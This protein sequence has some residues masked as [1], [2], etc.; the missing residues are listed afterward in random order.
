MP[1]GVMIVVGLAALFTGAEAVVRGAARLAQLLGARPLVIGLTIVGMGTSAPEV[2]VSAVAAARGESAVAL[3]NVLGSNIANVGL[4]LALAALVCPMRADI[5]L[6]RRETPLLLAFSVGCYGLAWTGA[7]T[8][9]QGALL[10]VGLVAF[11]RLALRWA[12][13]EPVAIEREF[14]EFEG[15]L[16]AGA[17][18]PVRATSFV[19]AGLILLLVGG[20]VLVVAAVSL[21]RSAGISEAAIAATLVAAGTSLPELATSLVAAAR[22]QPDIAVGNIIGSNLFNLLGVL[23][24]AAVIRPVEVSLAQRDFEFPVML[25]F[26]AAAAVMLRTG[27]RFTRVEGALLLAAYAAFCWLLLR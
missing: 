4:I 15:K 5:G 26:T 18:S 7:Y 20:H 1:D 2:V 11:V 13:S 8:R 14:A 17:S 27:H 6:L 22:R 3:G 12:R 21:A 24:L 9:W 10:L 16:L 23:G 25:A 19:A